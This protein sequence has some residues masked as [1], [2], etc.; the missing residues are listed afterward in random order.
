V[1][2]VQQK[3]YNVTDYFHKPYVESTTYEGNRKRCWLESGTRPKSANKISQLIDSIVD[4]SV[5]TENCKEK[6]Q[7]I[8]DNSVTRFWRF[9]GTH[10]KEAWGTGSRNACERGMGNGFQ[11]HMRKTHAKRDSEKGQRKARGG[12]KPAPLNLAQAVK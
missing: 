6:L 3:A 4:N 7:K 11:E 5:T 12:P 1:R 8:G 9:P 2:I 10:A